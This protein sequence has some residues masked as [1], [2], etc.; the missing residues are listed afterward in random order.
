MLLFASRRAVSAL[1]ASIFMMNENPV[2]CHCC[3]SISRKPPA[4]MMLFI[5]I[6]DFLM[7]RAVRCRVL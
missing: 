7:V 2:A 6:C 4:D 3:I 1:E 5:A